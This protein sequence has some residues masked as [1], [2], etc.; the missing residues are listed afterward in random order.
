[1]MA[2]AAVSPTLRGWVSGLIT[3]KARAFYAWVFLRMPA[4]LLALPEYD[5]LATEQRVLLLDALEHIVY[6]LVRIEEILLPDAGLGEEKKS[7]VLAKLKQ[8]GIPA[9]VSDVAAAMIDN[10]VVAMNTEAQAALNAY[11]PADVTAESPQAASAAA[12]TAVKPPEASA[13]AG[14]N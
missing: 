7:R 14:G 5:A 12:D 13:N 1:M 9:S 8:L 10:A 3:A 11:R 2:L 6:Y 4:L